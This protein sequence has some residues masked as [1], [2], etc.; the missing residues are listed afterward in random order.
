MKDKAADPSRA[1]CRHGAALADQAIAGLAGRQ[2]GVVSS[3]QLRAAGIDRRAASRRADAGRLHRLHRGVY[4]VGHTSLT[5]EGRWLAAVL[6]CGEGAVLSHRSAAAL[7]RLTPIPAGP[8]DV[9]VSTSAGRRPRSGIRLHRSASLSDKDTAERE[10]I[11][12]TAPARTLADLRR[13]LSQRRLDQVI[14]A[15]ELLRL[16]VGT[17][18]GFEQPDLARS[19]LERRFMALCRR[20]RL[21]Q[22]LIN[23]IVGPYEVDFLWPGAGVIVEVDGYRFHGT[24]SA[25]EADRAR[26]VDLKL[27]GYGVFRFTHRQLVKDGPAIIRALRRLLEV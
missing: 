3:R 5:A 24:R 20:H 8:I 23:H 2:Y 7:W 13:V 27:M 19:E 4:A 21:P 11:P 26:D 16:D 1:R 10:R 15:A 9:T 25:F 22:P 17:Q 12:V 18:P 6:A 14:R